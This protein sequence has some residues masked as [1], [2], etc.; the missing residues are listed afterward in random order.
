M[1]IT[2]NHAEFLTPVESL[3]D[4]PTG[5]N[6]S[7]EYSQIANNISNLP[8]NDRVI[9]FSG[10]PS[11]VTLHPNRAPGLSQNVPFNHVYLDLDGLDDYIYM[12]GNMPEDP[13]QSVGTGNFE[14]KFNSE[15]NSWFLYQ[16]NSLSV[17]LTGGQ[18]LS[19]TN[20]GY[21][22]TITGVQFQGFNN[23]LVTLTDSDFGTPN[24]ERNAKYSV[25]ITNSS[26]AYFSQND[27]S[28]WYVVEI[29]VSGN[30]L[31]ITGDSVNS[32]GD[33]IVLP[34]GFS[35]AV[36]W[37]NDQLIT[38]AYTLPSYFQ[39]NGFTRAYGYAWNATIPDV[40]YSDYTILSS[41]AGNS[42]VASI[43]INEYAKDE[44]TKFTDLPYPVRKLYV[45]FERP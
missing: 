5:F 8:E 14:T 12:Q 44:V 3:I 42:G 45:T 18:G 1:P 39:T 20:A 43:Q 32:S 19:P 30:D 22:N 24:L 36:Y 28:S 27:H 23:A 31:T 34:H 41:N 7:F 40:N 11:G 13:W 6:Q 25:E 26:T 17:F 33:Y 21:D 38:G 9:I 35:G 37:Q 2:I 4:N 29:S 15:S 16:L 10:L